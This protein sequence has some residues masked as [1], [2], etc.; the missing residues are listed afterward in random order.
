MAVAMMIFFPHLRVLAQ[1]VKM[2]ILRCRD[3]GSMCN[4]NKRYTKQ[5]TQEDY[6][7]LYTGPNFLIEVRLAQILSTI[8]VTMTYSS[9]LPILYLVAALSFVVGYWTDKALL[10][11]YYS[12]TP[13]LTKELTS[14]VIGLLLWAVPIHLAFSG[15]IFSSPEIL[16]SQSIE[17]FGNDT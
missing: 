17:W 5:L 10:L 3:R 1:T 16:K 7:G 6:E 9:G 12:L 14:H 15:I 13:G 8:F 11:K 2:S 4:Y